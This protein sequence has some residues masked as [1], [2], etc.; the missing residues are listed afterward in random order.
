V[1]L[2]LTDRVAI[3]TGASKG[4]GQA[5][6]HLLANEGASLVL[7][8]RDDVQLDSAIS[9]LRDA[10]TE[11]I[12]IA[13]DVVESAVTEAIVE[14]ALAAFG[15]ID[16][17]VNNAGGESG[18]SGFDELTDEDWER[19]YRLNVVAPSRLIRAVLPVMRER[20]WGRIVN[21]SSYT[22][23][24]PEPFC[25]PYAA[26][27]AALVNLTRGLSRTCAAE[28]ILVNCVLP[29]LTAT[30]GVV[31]RFAEAANSSGRSS[32]DLLAAML[33]RAPIDAGRMGTPMEVAAMIGFLASEQASWISGSAFAVDGGTVRTAS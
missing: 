1:D 8:A 33:R 24:V 12:G 3:V 7:C 29:G 6:A 2:G 25:L 15:R 30:N 5:T 31:E 20:G 17:V 14:A 22:A 4:I 26:A 10:G 13:G 32:E 28:G 16:V 19:V 27:K 21:V 9:E 23:R 11:A 18:R